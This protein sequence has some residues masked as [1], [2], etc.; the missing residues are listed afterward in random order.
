MQR[1]YFKRRLIR[2]TLAL[3]QFAEELGYQVV[4]VASESET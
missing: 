1:I 2:N 3:Q 4:V